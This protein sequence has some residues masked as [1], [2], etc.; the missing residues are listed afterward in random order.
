VRVVVVANGTVEDRPMYHEVIRGADLIICADGGAN[1]AMRFGWSP[2]VIVGDMDSVAPDVLLELE[3]A[4][5]EVVRHSPRKDET[6]LELAL[7]EAVSRGAAE[8]VVL[9]ATGGRIDHTVANMMLLSL[10][11]LADRQVRMITGDTEVML[12]RDVAHVHGHLG[13]TVSLIPIGGDADGVSTDGLEWQLCE[14]TLMLGYAR[15][16]SNVMTSGI[17]RIRV[18]RGLLLLTHAPVRHPWTP[19]VAT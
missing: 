15:G 12:V 5:C 3:R 2:Q 19:K 17:A 6:D 14:E 10:P 9:G 18:E 13:D 16:V 7:T 4:G 1:G 11:E 8:I